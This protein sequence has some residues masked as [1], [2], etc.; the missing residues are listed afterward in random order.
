[1]DKYY[2]FVNKKNIKNNFFYLEKSLIN[3]VLL[4]D[5]ALVTWDL[6][7]HRDISLENRKMDS[8]ITNGDNCLL[9]YLEFIL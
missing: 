6:V 3:T 9:F 1:M 7:N 5:A 2:F 4:M 8:H